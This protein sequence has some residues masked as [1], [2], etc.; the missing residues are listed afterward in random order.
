VVHFVGFGGP[1]TSL[2]PGRGTYRLARSAAFQGCKDRRKIL[3]WRH[4][5]AFS[6]SVSEC[7]AVERKP[8]GS[9]RGFRPATGRLPPGH[10]QHPP[11]HPPGV[12]A[13]S[14]WRPGGFRLASGRLPFRSGG[15]RAASARK[16]RGFRLAS[17]RLPFSVRAASVSVGRKPRGSRAEA[18]APLSGAAPRLCGRFLLY[19]FH[20]FTFFTTLLFA[21]SSECRSVCVALVAGAGRRCTY[22]VSTFFTTLP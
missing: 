13:A 17:A 22:T 21:I 10:R 14:A 18:A 20:Y 7:G 8:P 19:F 3:K 5:R 16:P 9:R 2:A 12:R 15:F 6:G 4:M 11:Q 1:A